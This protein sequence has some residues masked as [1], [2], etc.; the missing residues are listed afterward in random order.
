MTDARSARTS[1]QVVLGNI[2]PSDARSSRV[3]EQVIL[4]NVHPSDARSA[5]VSMQVVI[6]YI[7][8]ISGGGWGVV[9]IGGS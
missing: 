5:R 2:N 3:S 1:E 6:P 4:D 8:V 7:K 9:S